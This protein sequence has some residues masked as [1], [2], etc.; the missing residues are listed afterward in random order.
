MSKVSICVS[1]DTKTN[2]KIK[3]IAKKREMSVSSLVNSYIKN[4]LLTEDNT[5]DDSN[6]LQN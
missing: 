6:I 2:K 4:F 5:D 1:M 3:N